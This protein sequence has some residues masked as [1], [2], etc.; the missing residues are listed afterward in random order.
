MTSPTDDARRHADYLRGLHA[1][2]IDTP[3]ALAMTL[4]YIQADSL[5]AL[6]DA[7]LPPDRPKPKLER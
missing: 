3:D 2:G 6:Q 1:L 7:P 5:R 4:A